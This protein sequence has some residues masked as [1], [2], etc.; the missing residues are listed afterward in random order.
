MTELTTAQ[1]ATALAAAC[2]AVVA[3][4]D[5]LT[6]ADQAIGD[7][8]HGLGMARGFGAAAAALRAEGAEFASVGE[9]FSAA[10]TAVLETSGGASGAIFGTM[11]RA[12][13]KALPGDVLDAEALAT[14][15]ETGAQKVM[16]RGKAEVGQKTM[17]DALVPAA[18]AA[19]KAAAG[20][21]DLPAVARAAADAAAAGRDATSDMVAKFGKAKSLGERSLGHPDPGAMSVTI[22]ITAL[23]DAI[24]AV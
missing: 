10:G 17:L 12:P 2:D 16:E 20:G 9:V 23:A 14:A 18:A 11:L 4:K 5:T 15:L 13:K 21:A 24:D 6:K 22:L 7:G 3:A 8:D 19:R 1:A